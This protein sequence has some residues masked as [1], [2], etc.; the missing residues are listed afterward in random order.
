VL[1]AIEDSAKD[2]GKKAKGEHTPISSALEAE[3]ADQ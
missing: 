3:L 1:A 2:P